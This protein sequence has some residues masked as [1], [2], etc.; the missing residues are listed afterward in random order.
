MTCIIGIEHGGH[1]YIGGDSAGVCDNMIT[2]RADT[3]VFR[4]Q[5]MLFGFSQS[6]RRGQVLKYKLKIPRHPKD[7]DDLQYMTTL[8]VDEVRRRFMAN[9]VM[10]H[11]ADAEYGGH[12]IVGYKGKV[13]E[14]EEDYQVA[15]YRDGFTVIG[16]GAEYAMGSLDT[17]K[18]MPEL[19]KKPEDRI[20]L[21]LSSAAYFST[22]VCEPFI[23]D[24]I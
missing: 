2:A 8:F 22:G 20:L 24:K 11:Y 9:G 14:I 4:R 19:V 13:Y 10:E 5:N 18:R 6:F 1:V 3:K 15:V 7:M 17:T 21:A 16:C 23:I 12:F